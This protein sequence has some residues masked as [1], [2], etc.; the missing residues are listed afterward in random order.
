MSDTVLRI[1]PVEPSLVPGEIA[2]D[3]AVSLLRG[4]LPLA[5]E[6]RVQVFE[7]T[8]FIDCGENFEGTFCPN[9]GCD[10]TEPWTE[11]MDTAAQL[12]FESLEVQLPCCD[13]ESNLNELCYKWPAGF[14][15]FVL[16]A[17][18]P[19]VG[20]WLTADVLKGIEEAVGSPVRQVL[21]HY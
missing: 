6:V 19:G 15:Q 12:N 16:E 4:F 8:Q 18:N 17:Q 5:E 2:R 7:A 20:G 14:A 11:W 13:K 1:F 10:L 9:C 21:A 3:H